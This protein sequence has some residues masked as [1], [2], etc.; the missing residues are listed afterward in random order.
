MR[1]PQGYLIIT[2]PYGADLECDTFTCVH[3]NTIVPVQPAPAPMPGGFC[4]MCRSFV[5]DSCAD[6]ECTPFEKQLEAWEAKDRARRS[7]GFK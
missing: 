3:C 2:S 7:M 5:C 1:R 6:K 4:G